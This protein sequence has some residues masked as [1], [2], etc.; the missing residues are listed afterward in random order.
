MSLEDSNLPIQQQDVDKVPEPEQSPMTIPPQAT[1]PSPQIAAMEIHHH[2]KVEK[3]NFKE[4]FLEFIMIFLAV[5]MGFFAESYR[6]HS[7]EK[8][9]SK[10]YARSLIHD[11]V[12]DTAMA[13]QTVRATLFLNAK[14][15]SI[16]TFIRGKK[17]SDLSNAQLFAHTH[18]ICLYKPYTWSRA[19][20][21]EIKS[22]GA[23]GILETIV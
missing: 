10:E 20:L 12:K 4:Y 15:D 17:I 9:R 22:S 3:K 18:F 11:L 16:K 6:E 23:Y 1:E 13:Q 7:V 2:P 21:E 8:S 14:I 19:T 5:T